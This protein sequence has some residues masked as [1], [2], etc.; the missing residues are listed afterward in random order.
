MSQTK[1][2]SLVEAITNTVI[3]FGINFTANLIILP[4]VLGIAVP[5]SANLTIGIIFTAIS[6][7]R[8]YILRRFCNA[9]LRKIIKYVCSKGY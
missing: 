7:I 1:S 5:V 3:G 6:V 8:S 9:N 4:L 2:E